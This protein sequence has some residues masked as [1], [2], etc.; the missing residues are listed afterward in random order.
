M[1]R[2][3]PTPLVSVALIGAGGGGLGQLATGGLSS[4]GRWEI[5]PLPTGRASAYPTRQQGRKQ[6][7]QVLWVCSRGQS[8]RHCLFNSQLSIDCFRLLAWLNWVIREGVV[9]PAVGRARGPREPTYTTAP[10]LG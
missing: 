2:D 10:S 9:R 1:S 5:C 7:V 8:L 4:D 3:R 6:G